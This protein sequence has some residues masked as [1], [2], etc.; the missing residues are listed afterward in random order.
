MPRPV[1][2]GPLIG[3]TVVRNEGDIVGQV[4][5]HA[6]R[7]HDLILV[8]DVCSWDDTVPEI[9]AVSREHPHVVLI[10][11]LPRPTF[12]ERTWRHIW[13]RFR[14]RV[15][16][17]TWWS[18]VDGDEFTD[19]DLRQAVARAESEGAD[20]IEGASALFFYTESE[21]RA[22][23]EGREGL[24]DRARSIEERRW[25]YRMDVYS[26][27]LFRQSKHLRWLEDTSRPRGLL[28][29]ASRRA[30]YRHYQYR[31]LDQIAVR[32]RTRRGAET[33]E[34]FARRHF[35]WSYAETTCIGPDDA[36]RP[37]THR[38]GEELVEDQDL[39]RVWVPG[40]HVRATRWVRERLY[41]ARYPQPPPGDLLA[42]VDVDGALAR[43][44]LTYR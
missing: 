37:R 30:N 21:A 13:D 43:A 24:A 34:D 41:A 10:T 18:Y 4:L 39:P 31:D 27:R 14:T 28:R 26:M 32:V 19:H 5:R 40:P 33:P 42:D 1:P 25:L 29:P 8:V 38:A 23:R 6:A 15:P 36:P 11:S 2:S 7:N 44:R 22:W 9:E 12:A 17:E 3:L 16:A 20:H 35:H